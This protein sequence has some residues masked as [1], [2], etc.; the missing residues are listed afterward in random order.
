MSRPAST[1]A[2]DRCLRRS[3]LIAHLAPRITGL[4]GR[5]AGR[6]S[7]LLAL[8]EEELIAAAGGTAK[9]AVRDRIGRFDAA[10]ERAQLDEAGAFAVCRHSASYPA[11]IF[12]AIRFLSA[13]SR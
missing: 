3:R 13:G 11:R 5:R 7:G 10:A 4:L 12:S 6:A 2:C 9:Q 8:P 1:E